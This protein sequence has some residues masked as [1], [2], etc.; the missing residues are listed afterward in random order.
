M[1]LATVFDLFKR[2]RH[3]IKYRE[4]L[5]GSNELLNQDYLGNVRQNSSSMDFDALYALS[6]SRKLNRL[7]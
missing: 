2:Y 5:T 6:I 3:H 1:F 7:A 4:L